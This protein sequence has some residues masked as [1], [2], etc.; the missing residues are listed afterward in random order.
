MGQQQACY[1]CERM[2][3]PEAPLWDRIY[4]TP[5][6]TVVHSYNCGLLG[7][8]VLIPNRHVEA[9]SE[10][11]DDEAVELGRL[12]RSVSRALHQSTGCIKTYIAQF[13]E[14]PLHTHVHFHVVAR[15]AD[16]PFEKRG[17]HIFDYIGVSDDQRVSEQ[18][19]NEL[20]LKVRAYLQSNG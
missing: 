13:A 12:Q 7:W 2:M 1:T 8:L 20:V 16:Q 10:L 19:M 3:R 11:T 5:L 14:H 18:A 17:P 6:W 4:Q 15:Y 9:V